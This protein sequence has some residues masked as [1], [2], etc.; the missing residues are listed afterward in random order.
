M[1]ARLS[2]IRNNIEHALRSSRGKDVLLYLLCFLIAFVFWLF[3]ALDSDAQ[4]DFRVPVEITEMPD[5]VTLIGNFPSGIDVSVKGKESQ[6][7]RFEW[8]GLSAIKL[9]WSE[10]ADDS[11]FSVSQAKL[12]T[13]LRD[14][15]GVSVNILACRP[16]S[17]SMLYSSQPGRKV[18]LIVAADVQPDFRYVIS[19]PVTASSDS[20]MVYSSTDLPH[21]L[22]SVETEPLIRSGLKDSMR[23]EVKVKPIPGVRIIPDKVTVMVPVEPLI[24][25]KTDVTV[26]VTN[27]P[28]GLRLVTFPPKVELT[29]L[30]PIS[31]YN[32]DYPFKAFVDYDD[33]R[34]G[35]KKIPVALASV[36]SL[37]R[38]ASIRPDSV[39]YIIEKIGK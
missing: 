18:K 3:Q 4:R 28:E 27:L 38:S 6:L 8:G 25:K 14:Y 31:N 36:P 12:D 9:K 39:E 26:T 11:R 24:S 13:R 32:D 15:F 23:Y 37:F 29:Y 5:S 22:T 19:G 17:I 7:L 2:E 34:K 20:V 33:A 35:R 30:V 21:S 10:C 16:D 1:G